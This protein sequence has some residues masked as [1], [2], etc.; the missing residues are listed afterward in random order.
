MENPIDGDLYVTSWPDGTVG[1]K[2]HQGPGIFLEAVQFLPHQGHN[3]KLGQQVQ[4]RLCPSEFEPAENP[5]PRDGRCGHAPL[6][7]SIDDPLHENGRTP[8]SEEINRPALG[9]AALL[10]SLSDPGYQEG[11]GG[12]RRRSHELDL[13]LAKRPASLTGGFGSLIRKPTAG[14]HDSLRYLEGRGQRGS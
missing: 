7:P 11:D 3:T 6:G 4:P 9:Q 1:V 2:C 10:G 13:G 8:S 14:Y 5:R 12:G